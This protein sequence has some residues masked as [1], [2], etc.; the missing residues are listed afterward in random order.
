MGDYFV[1]ANVGVT[2]SPVLEHFTAAVHPTKT[3]LNIRPAAGIVPSAPH[4]LVYNNSHSG[5][6]RLHLVELSSDSHCLPV[7]VPVLYCMY[8]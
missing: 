4:C 5:S 2:N 1:N 8:T 7:P 3:G 6:K